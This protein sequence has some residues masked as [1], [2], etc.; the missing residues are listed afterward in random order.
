MAAAANPARG[1][2]RDLLPDDRAM[3]EDEARGFRMACEC[4][5]TWGLRIEAQGVSLGGPQTM[6]PMT[7][8]MAH[9]GKMVRGCAEALRLTIGS[10]QRVAVNI[11]P[12]L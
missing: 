7:Q 11:I 6:V 4:L 1:A 12:D 2:R 3:T 8:V 5:I 10:G 9:G